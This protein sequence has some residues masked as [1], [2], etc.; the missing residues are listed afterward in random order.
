MPTG[1]CRCYFLAEAD[2]PLR[3]ANSATEAAPPAFSLFCLGFFSSR[4]LRFAMSSLVVGRD[5]SDGSPSCIA[6]ARTYEAMGG[7]RFLAR[8]LPFRQVTVPG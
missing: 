3:D 2:F 4:S 6:G 1:A 5:A 8:F 7:T